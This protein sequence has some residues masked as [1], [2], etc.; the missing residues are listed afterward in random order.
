[1]PRHGLRKLTRKRPDPCK[2][3]DTSGTCEMRER[4]SGKVPEK[5]SGKVRE[6]GS[7]GSKMHGN[8][9]G[10]QQMS[11][12]QT[13]RCKMPSHRRSCK[14]SVCSTISAPDAAQREA[15]RC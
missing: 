10:P 9:P 14:A 2:G 13:D 4:R 3:T 11:E 15:V 5:R 7:G 8:R 12:L 1:M 6:R